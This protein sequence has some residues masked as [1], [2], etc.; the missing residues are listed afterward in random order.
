MEYRQLPHGNEKEIISVPGLGLGSIGQ[1][2][3]D[4]NEAK[5]GTITDINHPGSVHTESG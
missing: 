3:P 5:D 1:T 4:E 2:A